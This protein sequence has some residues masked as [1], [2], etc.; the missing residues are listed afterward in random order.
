MNRL[1]EDIS[2]YI[3]NLFKLKLSPLFIYHDFQH[4]KDVALTAS[5]MADYYSLSPNDKELILISAWFHDTG[6]IYSIVNHEEHS[7]AIAE[8]Y[9]N[10]KN[11]PADRI[12]VIKRIILSTKIPRNPQNLIE[13]ILCDAD[14]AYIGSENL[15]DKIKQ[16]RMEWEKTINKRY[17]DY[18]WLLE[19]ISFIEANPF[20]TDYAKNTFS[21]IRTNNLINLKKLAAE[22]QNNLS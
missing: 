4:T 16:L 9:L 5:G 19:N 18:D 14:I 21:D 11:Y 20:Y 2:L 1:I 3:E 12:A 15:N 6:Y 8:N 22:I 17:S 13:E 10:K 7:N